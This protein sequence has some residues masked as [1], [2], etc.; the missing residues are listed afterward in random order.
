MRVGDYF[1]QQ[2]KALGVGK[3]FL[4]SG[5][6]MMHLI[7]AIASNGLDYVCCHHEQACAMAAEAYAR[8]T[9]RLGACYATS[10]PGATNILTGLIG[11]WQDSSPVIFFTGQAK[12]SQTIALAPT[13]GLRQFGTFEVDIVPVVKSVTKYATMLDDLSKVRFHFEKAVHLATTGRPGPVLLD[14]PLDVQGAQIDPDQQ[15]GFTPPQTAPGPSIAD[16]DAVLDRLA[17]S[18]RPVLLVGHGVRSAGAVPLLRQVVDRLGAPAILTQL[19]KDALAY[20]HPLF[21]G[22]SGPK[23]DRAGNFALQSADFILSLGCSLH[24]QTVGYEADLYALGAYK[25]QVDIERPIL[26]RGDI[27]VD[28]RIEADVTAFLE[29]LLARVKG[30]N[31]AYAPWVERCAHW[32]NA[33]AVRAEPHNVSTPEINF[34]ELAET[35][36][37]SLKGGESIITDAG[38]AFYVMGQAFRCRG[39]QRYIVSGAMGAMGFA[40]PGAIGLA[41]ASPDKAII[42]VTGDGSLQTNIQELQTIKHNQ[43]NVKLVVVSNDGYASIRNTQKG[44]FAGA[45]VGASRDSGVSTPDLQKIAAAYGLAYVRIADRKRMGAAIEE[46]VSTRGP[47]VIE[48]IAQPDQVIIPTVTSMKMADGSLRSTPLHLMF[49]NLAPEVIEAE[50]GDFLPR[51]QERSVA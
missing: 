51:G 24:A 38:S 1:A 16:L 21:V 22:H 47:V 35:L 8:E 25:V 41:A 20:D 49:P 6:G 15:E 31:L 36:S 28:K 46:A 27:P 5:G 11:A 48:V 3:V 13:P 23:G 43:M 39:D 18:Q 7:D 44:F 2:L 37:I 9:G 4:V 33:Y 10:G 40:L 32:K 14:V 19:A 50:V 12:R 42:C 34:Y 30:P 17:R 26:E 29:M 45:F